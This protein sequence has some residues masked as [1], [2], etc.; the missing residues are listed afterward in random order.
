[1]LLLTHVSFAPISNIQVAYLKDYLFALSVEPT[2]TFVIFYQVAATAVRWR[3]QRSTA[4]DGVGGGLRREGGARRGNATTSQ[5]DERTRGR[6]NERTTRDDGATTSWRDAKM[7]GDTTR[8]R[9]DERAVHREATQQPSGASR[10]WRGAQREDKERRCDNK[11][12]RRVDER[13]AQREDGERPCDN[14]QRQCDN[15][16]ER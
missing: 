1:M 3:Q 9:D 5:N 13:V 4:Y 10:G 11:L 6:C 14:Q 2:L 8:Q 16:R 7:R 15:Q 12:A